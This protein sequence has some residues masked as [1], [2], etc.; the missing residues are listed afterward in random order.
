[1]DVYV[2]WFVL[3]YVLKSLEVLHGFLTVGS[4][5]RPDSSYAQ[6]KSFTVPVVWLHYCDPN[7]YQSYCCQPDCIFYLQ[8]N[9]SGSYEKQRVAVPD[10]DVHG[11]EGQVPQEP[12]FLPLLQE[13]LIYSELQLQAWRCCAENERRINHMEQ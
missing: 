2:A 9:G 8:L 5:P 6:R 7:R 12:A 11:M 3:L 1:M 4:V 10:V 13:S